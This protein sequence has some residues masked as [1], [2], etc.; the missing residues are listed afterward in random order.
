MSEQSTADDW[1]TV[2]QAAAALGISERRLRRWLDAPE[3]AA[4]KAAG[5]R[6]EARRTRTG[7]RRAAL[8]APSLIE[9][10][11]MDLLERESGTEHGEKTARNPAPDAAQVGENMAE[12]AA[13]RVQSF[14]A[15]SAARDELVSELRDMN[16]FLRAALEARDR[17]A[18][19]LRAAL[20]E[21]LKLSHRALLE[22]AQSTAD[23]PGTLTASRQDAP[24]RAQSTAEAKESPVVV[25]SP[26][27]EPQREE[28]GA[29]RFERARGFRAWLLK[30]LRG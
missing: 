14:E 21:A 5:S 18:A 19:E 22:P 6:Q 24:E 20:R 8:L 30:V 29:G 26:Q 10:A 28:T 4:R 11:R 3:N 7:T 12:E 25:E 1:L 23:A 9:A 27:I 16:A 17:D 13:R 2:S 15:S